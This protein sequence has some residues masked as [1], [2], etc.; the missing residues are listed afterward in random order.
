[1]HDKIVAMLKNFDI[2][3]PKLFEE[4]VMVELL[5]NQ[6]EEKVAAISKF[7]IFWKLTAEDYP[8]Y[9][10]FPDGIVLY[11][12]LEYLENKDP[13]VRLSSKSWISESTRHFRRVLDPLINLLLAEDT[14]VY[15]TQSK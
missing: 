13:T 11:N 9:V 2:L 5:S 15:I 10:A 6:R 12:I 8:R 1:M 14:R 4:V 7:S 3:M